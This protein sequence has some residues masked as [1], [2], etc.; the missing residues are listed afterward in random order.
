LAG[1][2]MSRGV[3][4][5]GRRTLLASGRAVDAPARP[6]V[7]P[8]SDRRDPRCRGRPHRPRPR[9]GG[10]SRRCER[11]AYCASTP[12]V[13]A[14]RDRCGESARRR[15]ARMPE[16]RS[17]RRR[18]SG[19]ARV[20]RGIRRA[21]RGLHRGGR[22]ARA[23]GPPAAVDGGDETRHLLVRPSFPADRPSCSIGWPTPRGSCSSGCLRFSC[24]CS[25]APSLNGRYQAGVE[26]SCSG[27]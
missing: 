13:H 17:P 2:P 16:S 18:R 11:G 9:R 1:L 23:N 14:G 19:R 21:Q 8:G 6:R 27:K 25:I 26:L 22:V 5:Q 10:R 20:A 4:I 7:E 24:S 3:K 12:S 15:R